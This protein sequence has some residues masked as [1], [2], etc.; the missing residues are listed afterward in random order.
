MKIHLLEASIWLPRPIDHVF[1]FFS[2]AY[3]LETLTPP[4]VNFR[5]LTPVPIEMR[6]GARIQYR[7]KVHGIPVGW[8]SEITAW[9]PPHGFV[10]EQVRG[11]YRRWRHQHR[12]LSRAGGTDVSD[13]V[14]YSVI[15]GAV[16]NY[17]FVARDVGAIFKY[18]SQKLAELFPACPS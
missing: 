6:P 2:D 15:G 7:L 1:A 18:R 13:R 10:D 8:E 9:D 3:N 4:F 16:V 17:L 5:V 14:E 11:P 12:F